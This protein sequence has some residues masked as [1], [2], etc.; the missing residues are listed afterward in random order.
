MLNE[1]NE[2]T[3][4]F[5]TECRSPI[6]GP[7]CFTQAASCSSP[8]SSSMSS[9]NVNS[10]D[11]EHMHTTSLTGEIKQTNEESSDP[12]QAVSINS[13][14]EEL[15]KRMQ[16]P[17]PLCEENQNVSTEIPLTNLLNNKFLH[18]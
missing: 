15:K 4:D 5:K 16:Q 14:F 11:S 12:K 2:T 8:C 9:T 3:M 7:S 18:I 17:K 13:E 6:S 1:L 10:T